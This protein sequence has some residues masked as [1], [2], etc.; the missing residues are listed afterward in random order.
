MQYKEEKR[1]Y[2]ILLPIIVIT[3]L[4]LGYY[5]LAPHHNQAGAK[6]ADASNELTLNVMPLKT[7]DVKIEKS[8]IGY[9]TPINDVNVLPYING[10]LEDILVEGG[11]EVKQGDTLIIIRQNEYKARMDAAKAEV[12]QAEA[13]FN[14]A[15]VYYKRIK[16]AGPKAIS[17]T[18]VDNAKASFLSTQAQVANAKA[19]YELAKV[20]YEY[21]IIQAPISGLVGNVA[22]TKGDYVS[23][24][25]EPLLRIIQFNPI[26]VVF[27]ITDK[28]YLEEI[29]SGGL[30]LNE[31][32][33]LK[34]SDGRIFEK[35]GTY[36]FADNEINKNTNSIAVFADFENSDK[37]LVS[38]A[39]VD[40][41]VEKNYPDGVLINQNLVT[42]TSEGNYVYLVNNNRLDK[43][44]IDIIATIGSQYLVK[45]GF[46][47]GDYIVLDKIGRIGKDQ[48]IKI[49]IADSEDSKNK[50]ENK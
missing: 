23:P 1:T 40:V 27:S 25:S 8:Y 11:Q 41:L 47:Q 5:A 45:N 19:N 42:M 9:V 37:T 16:D 15:K 18:E 22:L 43:V 4:V 46:K 35:A 2:S 33:K 49:K 36:K 39:Y 17:K 48:K 26:R 31:K 14:N 10:F 28:D 44:K 6:R 29:R 7:Q 50:G 38:N 20:N 30:F 13:N 3:A 12:M 34:L 21:T 24:A 32:I